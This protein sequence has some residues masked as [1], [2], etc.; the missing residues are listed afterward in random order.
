MKALWLL[1][2]ALVA[3]GTK[4]EKNGAERKAQKSCAPQALVSDATSG[5]CRIRLVTPDSCASV[6]LSGGKVYEL[7]WTTDGT[8]CET[9]WK[10]YLAGN[11]ANPE[12]GENVASYR[13]STNGGTITQRGGVINIDAAVFNDLKSTDGTYH[14]VVESFYGSR[15]ASKNFKLIK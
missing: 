3:C 9:P 14:W 13:L 5:G 6:D 7:A 1:S 8:I 15:P 2:L 10:I 11:P 12:T 4:E